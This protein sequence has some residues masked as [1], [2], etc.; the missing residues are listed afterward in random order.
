[1]CICMYIYIYIHTYIYMFEYFNLL[2]SFSEP[3][4]GSKTVPR[5][6]FE[7][8]LKQLCFRLHIRNSPYIN[9]KPT[10]IYIY[11]YIHTHMHNTSLS[12]YMYMC[13]CMYI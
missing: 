4:N 8:M 10:N 2:L 12:L 1:M 9:N 7:A 3:V 6:A 5:I 11:I 13:I